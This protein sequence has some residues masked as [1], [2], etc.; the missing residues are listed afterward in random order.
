[1]QPRYL[2]SCTRFGYSETFPMYSE[3][4]EEDTWER[5]LRLYRRHC[6]DGLQRG[7]SLPLAFYAATSGAG[8]QERS[9]STEEYGQ[10]S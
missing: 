3:A 9:A 10:T 7:R 1:M 8:E 5:V 4:A 6:Q 2:Q